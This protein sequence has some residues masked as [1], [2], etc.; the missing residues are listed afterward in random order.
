MAKSERASEL[1]KIAKEISNLEI[2]KEWSEESV[3]NTLAKVKR[4]LIREQILNEG[5]RADG[6]SLNEVRPI[7]IE[8]KSYQTLMVLVFSLVDKLKP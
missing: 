5:K 3:L 8:T 7:N 1:N 4:K 2:A 6:R